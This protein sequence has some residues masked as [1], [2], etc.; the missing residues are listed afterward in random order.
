MRSCKFLSS[1]AICV[2]SSC[3]EGLVRHVVWPYD[4]LAANRLTCVIQFERD[5]GLDDV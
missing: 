5:A 1:R 4:L 2:A 3:R